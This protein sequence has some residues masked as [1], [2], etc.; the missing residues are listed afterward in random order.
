MN[1]T[2]LRRLLVT[3][4]WTI[5]KWKTVWPGVFWENGLTTEVYDFEE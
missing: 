1:W 2:F 5:P 4:E 3:G